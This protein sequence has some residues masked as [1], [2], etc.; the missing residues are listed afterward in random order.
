MP[1]E[2]EAGK[3]LSKISGAATGIK[4]A[5]I[6]DSD[7]EMIQSF[8][9]NP[10]E[11]KREDVHTFEVDLANDQIDRD[12]ER[13][14]DEVLKSFARTLPGKS[15]LIAHQW[16]PPGKG[17]FYRARLTTVDGVK[18]LRTKFYVLKKYSESLIDHINAGIYKYVSIGFVA[19][20][21]KRVAEDDPDNAFGK[22]YWEYRNRK[23]EE[24]E[25]LEGSVVWLGAQHE[26]QIRK[27][28]GLAGMKE[29]GDD[30]NEKGRKGTMPVFLQIKELGGLKVDVSDEDK[31]ISAA[32]TIEQKVREMIGDQILDQEF[33][34]GLKGIFGTES[35]VK[36]ADIKA[37]KEDADRYRKHLVDEVVKFGSLVK[38]MPE[39]EAELEKEKK[40]LAEL[41]TARLEKQLKLF[42]EKFVAENPGAGVL[43]AAAEDKGDDNADYVEVR[44]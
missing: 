5:T 29:F 19:P 31:A 6:S 7:W 25:A 35:D 33:L 26:A 37:A 42:R 39:D 27:F 8:M 17:L 15:F 30:D 13:F 24:A 40:E 2:F 36:L 34:T 11:V 1:G 44:I 14:S 12:A 41:G 23:G 10:G 28:F 21:L 22:T 38:M 18:W 20:S 43:A 16:G 32:A 4:V 3:P 9:P